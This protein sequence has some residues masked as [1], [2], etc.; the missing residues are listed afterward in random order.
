MS[1]RNW[2][3][4]RA[5]V[6]ALRR[7]TPE[8]F[9]LSPENEKNINFYTPKFRRVG[10]GPVDMI[11]NSVHDGSFVGKQWDG[12]KYQVD[13]A[14]PS[15]ELSSLSLEITHHFRKIRI[16]YSGAFDFLRGEL[17]LHAWRWTIKETILQKVFNLHLRFR[18]DRIDV[19]NELISMYLSEA[20]ENE[21]SLVF[22]EGKSPWDI[23]S[24]IYGQRA[25]GQPSLTRE[26]ARFQLI[27]DSLNSSGDLEC[28]NSRY[29]VAA[30]ALSTI[31][32]FEEQER[33]HRDQV[34]HNKRILWLTVALVVA[35]FLVPVIN[36]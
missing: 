6:C 5:L 9:S 27:L 29:K 26:M 30:K 10:E 1:I 4:H 19:L 12:T 21:L 14:L 28:N 33:R 35:A 18:S 7:P 17:T 15:D 2:F 13:R 31:A 23:F 22:G 16:K 20:E 8:R 25:F 11:V 3:A 34:T 32:E 36:S 24:R